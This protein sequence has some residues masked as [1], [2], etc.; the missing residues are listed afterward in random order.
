MSWMALSSKALKMTVFVTSL[1]TST[2]KVW[3]FIF[4]F[5]F[6]S[7]DTDLWIKW[8]LRAVRLSGRLF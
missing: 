7:A 3:A 1:R 5:Y 6:E 2:P 4:Q 8:S